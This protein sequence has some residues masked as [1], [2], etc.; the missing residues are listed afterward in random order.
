M[1]QV[2]VGQKLQHIQ[3][4]VALSYTLSQIGDGFRASQDFEQQGIRVFAAFETSGYYSGFSLPFVN[5]TDFYN[6]A[7]R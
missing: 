3:D 5:F 2:H 4:E 7:L 6:I 1:V